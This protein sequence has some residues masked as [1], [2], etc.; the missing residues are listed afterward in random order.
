MIE[1]A[2]RRG[3]GRVRIVDIAFRD[4]RGEHVSTATAGSDLDVV[5]S[6]EAAEGR[7]VD[8]VSVLLI[9]DSPSGA[10]L[11]TI[12][13]DFSGD[14]LRGLPP[15]GQLVCRIGRLPLTGGTYVWSLK[16]RVGGGLA[17]QVMDATVLN[18]DGTGFYPTRRAPDAQAG[19]MLLDYRWKA[20]TA[21]L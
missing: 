19:P 13:N 7:P 15:K 1:R 2:D 5:L 11:A 14:A 10:R 12:S 20:V 9:V 6:Y 17:D 4:D 3:D 18:V 16:A 8:N 21:P